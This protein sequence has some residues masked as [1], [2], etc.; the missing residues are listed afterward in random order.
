[1]KWKKL[2]RIFKVEDINTTLHSHCMTTMAMQLDKNLYRIYFNSRDA[3]NKSR[4]HFVEIDIRN[5]C[6][7]LAL[8][9]TPVMDTGH[10][11][12]FDENGVVFTSYI[13]QKDRILFYY[14]GFPQTASQIFHAYVGLA[15]SD[16]GGITAQ[17]LYEGPV[18]S[19]SKDEPY[20]SAGPRVYKLENDQ[21]GM[22]YTACDGWDHF[23][24]GRMKHLYDIKYCTSED[25]IDWSTGQKAITYD[26]S[27]EY[28]LSI[29]SMIKDHSGYRMWYSYRA[30]ENISTYRIGY[31]S[32]QDGIDWIRK[33]KD[34]GVD[35]SADGWDSQ[36]IAYPYVFQHNNQLYMLYNGNEYGRSGFG[37]A[38]LE[39]G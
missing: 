9:E 2:G 17:R 32:S 20:F 10:M 6:E 11:G 25:G 31:A 22:W 39:E 35:V 15:Y 4:P 16:D 36:M 3:L 33:D 29:P 18:K 8:Q 37:I 24:D 27:Y 34:V 30:Q 14:S 12:A 26:N 7:I 38:I 21:Y 1:M 23:E 13:K 5:P 19:L 28:A